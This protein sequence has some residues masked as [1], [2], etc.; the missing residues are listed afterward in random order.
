MYEAYNIRRH[1][2][3]IDGLNTEI[4]SKLT[5]ARRPGLSVYN[6]QTFPAVNAF[7]SFHTFAEENTIRVV[8]DTANAV[9]DATGPNTKL[10]LLSK[11]AGAGQ[12]YFQS[13]GN[14]LFFGDGV[15][16]KK[17]VKSSKS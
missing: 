4:T 10:Q 6:S 5:L 16:L 1:D 9:Y 7:Y 3:L 8:A 2:T 17:W 13:V 15:D 14:T 11:S 12:T